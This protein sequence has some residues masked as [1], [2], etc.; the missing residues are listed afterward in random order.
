MKAS[1]KSKKEFS[2]LILDQGYVYFS[3]SVREK[4]R[5]TLNFEML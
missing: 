1:L 4:L 5:K 2:I 3:E